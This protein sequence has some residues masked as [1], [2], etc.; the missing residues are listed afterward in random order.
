LISPKRNDN[1]T[2][3]YS[4][5][6]SLLHLEHFVQHPRNLTSITTIAHTTVIVHQILARAVVPTVSVQAIIDIN[7][8]AATSESDRAITRKPGWEKFLWKQSQVNI[9]N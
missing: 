7:F 2:T 4:N 3:K 8:A 5:D 6:R 1:T 9:G